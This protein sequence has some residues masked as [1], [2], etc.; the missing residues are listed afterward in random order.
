MPATLAIPTRVPRLRLIIGSINAWKVDAIAKTLVS[1]TLSKTS[2]SSRYC[3]FTPTEIPAQAMAISTPP[4][5]A[6]NLR[7][8]SIKRSRSVTSQ[9]IA[10]WSS[11]LGSSAISSLSLSSRLATRPSVAPFAANSFA[12][13]CP[14]PL[15][16]PVRKMFI[17]YSAAGHSVPGE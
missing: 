17:C 15:D 6:S 11:G 5:A 14:M 10:V 8:S 13:A 7:A 3:V 9:T 4:Q 12:K 16:A 1:K 2:R